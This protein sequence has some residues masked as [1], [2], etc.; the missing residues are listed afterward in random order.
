METI[1]DKANTIQEAEE[2]AL[3]E[4]GEDPQAAMNIR[5]GMKNSHQEEEEE[6]R[7]GNKNP[8]GKIRCNRE[9]LEPNKCSPGVAET[10]QTIGVIDIVMWGSITHQIM[11]MVPGRER[12]ALAPEDI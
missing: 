1:E 8:G 6:D 12:E 3:Q 4:E 2:G 10:P 11:D 9:L 7:I 5:S